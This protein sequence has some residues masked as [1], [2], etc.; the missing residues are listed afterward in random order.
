MSVDAK[1][2]DGTI[3]NLNTT[4]T[5]TKGVTKAETMKDGSKM[6]KDA[7][8]QLLVAQMKYQDPMEPTDNTQYVAQL[9]QFS[10]LEAMNNMGETME[11]QRG[12]SLVGK[13]VK[14]SVTNETTG[15]TSED[16]GT[17]D[18][19]T[20]S[21]GKVYLTVNGNQYELDNV[22]EVLDSDYAEAGELAK[23]WQTAY[24]KLPKLSAITPETASSYQAQ[25]QNLVSLTNSMSTYQQSFLSKDKLQGLADYVKKLSDYGV[26][27]ET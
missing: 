24:D 10:S 7:F 9:A 21:G 4:A 1:I 16:S 8:L 23:T 5:D 14:V 3:T 13:T 25:V 27:I 17:V 11:L 26:K 12:T 15:V 6:D 20:K 18:A 19:V 2:L 22:K